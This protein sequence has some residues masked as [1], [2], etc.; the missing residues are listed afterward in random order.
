MSN[1]KIFV[2]K[3][4]RFSKNKTKRKNRMP[5]EF[6]FQIHKEHFFSKSMSQILHGAYMSKV[7]SFVL[8]LGKKSIIS[9]NYILFL[10]WLCTVI[11]ISYRIECLF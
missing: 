11:E 7:F 8:K 1:N 5:V 10:S 9:Y 3:T 6:D 2:G 4:A